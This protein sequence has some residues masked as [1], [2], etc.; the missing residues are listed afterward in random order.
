MMLRQVF[1]FRNF[2]LHLNR[3]RWACPEFV[4]GLAR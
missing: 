2:S 1:T 3:A 4:E